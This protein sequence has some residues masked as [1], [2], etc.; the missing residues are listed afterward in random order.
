MTRLKKLSSD[1]EFGEVF[2]EDTF[3]IGAIFDISNEV[4]NNNQQTNAIA[5]ETIGKWSVTLNTNRLTSATKLTL[6]L[7]SM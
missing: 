7:T 3:I 5:E 2:D 4:K 6:G 1:C